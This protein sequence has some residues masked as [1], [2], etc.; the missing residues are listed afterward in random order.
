MNIGVRETVNNIKDIEE[1]IKITAFHYNQME[2]KEDTV[3]YLRSIKEG[4]IILKYF[5]F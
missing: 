4:K 1:K 3:R 5:E 2:K